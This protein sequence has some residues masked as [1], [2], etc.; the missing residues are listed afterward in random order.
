M[1]YMHKRRF[2]ACASAFVSV[3][4]VSSAAVAQQ[5][6]TKQCL[7]YDSEKDQDWLLHVS[8]VWTKI[9]RNYNKPVS[10]LPPR[11]SEDFRPY[12]SISD[13]AADGKSKLTRIE[14]SAL[15]GEQVLKLTFDY[16]YADSGIGGYG[17]GINPLNGVRLSTNKALK[18]SVNDMTQERQARKT[19]QSYTGRWHGVEIRKGIYS[20]RFAFDRFGGTGGNHFHISD[21]AMNALL[22][23]DQPII[24]SLLYDGAPYFSQ[25]FPVNGA[26]IKGL[27]KI[28]IP[29][30]E[31][32]KRQQANG[33]CKSGCFITTAACEIVG[34]DDKCWEL[35]TLRAFRD[36]WMSKN[37][38]TQNEIS[39]YYE[40]APKIVA[41][42]NNLPHSDSMWKN[43]YAFY[44]LPASIFAKLKFNKAAYLFYKLMVKRLR[45]SCPEH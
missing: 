32:I 37:T 5:K 10:I 9:Q 7:I 17:I 20:E 29:R 26:F 25:N 21:S 27:F 45:K 36:G 15:Q 43:V 23:D 14:P 6:E 16:N 35:R 1:L 31:D 11:F 4:S 40:I 3:F 19:S 12:K 41:R 18:M 22:A 13:P 8:S 44:I 42:I 28:G 2:L 33:E 38:R 24:I 34:L 30:Y 39:I